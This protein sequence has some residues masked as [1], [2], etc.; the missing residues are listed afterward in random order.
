M[1]EA[2]CFS[3][4]SH[5]I[6]SIQLPWL[7]SISQVPSPTPLRK[8]LRGDWYETD[9]SDLLSRTI[10]VFEIIHFSFFVL[11]FVTYLKLFFYNISSKILQHV[12]FIT[13]SESNCCHFTFVR[14]ILMPFS[15]VVENLINMCSNDF[16]VFKNSPEKPRKT[17]FFWQKPPKKVD[18]S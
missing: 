7:P 12:P 17:L 14:S 18:F 15:K 16:L 5:L 11:L 8:L 13:D 3:L 9:F 2:T 1:M 10:L 6:P 4:Q